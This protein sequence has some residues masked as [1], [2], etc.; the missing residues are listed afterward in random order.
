V[1]RRRKGGPAAPPARPAAEAAAP[2]P[3]PR[4]ALALLGAGVLA[5]GAALFFRPDRPRATGAATA[6]RPNVLLVTVDTLRA[7]RLGSYGY[8]AAAT[9][10]LDALAASGVRF[11][12][13]TAHAPLTAPSHASILTGLTPPRH[14]VR[15]NGQA[16]GPAP[17]TLAKAFQSS[18]YATGAFVSGFPLDRRFGLLRGFE[19]YDDRLPHGDDARRASYVERPGPGTTAAALR[20]IDAV[21]AGRPW[22][23]WVHYFEPHSPYEPPAVLR[24][25]FAAHPYDGEVA[26]VDVEVGALLRRLEER[27][28]RSNTVVLVTADHGESLGEHGEETHGVFVYEATLRVPLIVAG[29]GVSAGVVSR[30]TAR[31]IDLF[32]TLL[33]LAGV[34][35]PGGVEGRS[36]RPALGG[37]ALPDAPVY[38]ESLFTRLNLGWAPLHSWRS[39]RFKL[40]DAPRPELF[41]LAADPG[42]TKDVAAAHPD[43]VESLRR[44][45]RAALSAAERAQAG[46][47]GPPT[48]YP[49]PE[50][51]RRLAALGYLGGGGGGDGAAVSGRDPKDG[52]ALVNRLE[53]AVAEARARPAWAAGELQAVLSADPGLSLAR[54]YRAVALAGAGDAAGAVRELQALEKAS[55]ARADDLVLLAECLRLSGRAPEALAALDRAAAL[56]PVQPDALLTR[57]QVLI[58]SGRAAEAQAA[59]ERILAARRD[60]AAA[61]RGLGDLALA[62]GDVAG[63]ESYYARVVRQEP[64]DARALVKLGIAQ[65][66]GGNVEAALTSF[67]EAVARDGGSPEA[68]LA[69]AGA[70]AKTGRAA[71]SLPYFERAVAAGARTP[72]A[73][74]GLGFAR[75][76]AGDARGALES[77]RA[78]LAVEPRQPD[79]AQAVAEIRRGLQ[80]ERP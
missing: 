62:R 8:A 26:A 76:Q 32:P 20:W 70:L 23:A 4:V 58:A 21:P 27:G 60:D 34:A 3:R 69:L 73:L 61:L 59:Y 2:R 64:Q 38:G 48:P 72:V 37:A 11:E 17:A 79:V 7:D 41:D 29:P 78:S 5:A 71:E 33:D 56:G 6:P 46:S 39:G 9:P 44:E 30:A 45:L 12:T 10:A 53:R 49:D 54:R 28:R 25:R 16:L 47:P 65:V 15:D 51:A 75:L 50:T 74:N 52:I 57:A 68:L 18:G 66:R 22:F 19:E 77:L 35:V 1:S 43:Q 36:L 80:A 14:G 42:E 31:G 40:V 67:R 13:A 24:A 55:A 63:A